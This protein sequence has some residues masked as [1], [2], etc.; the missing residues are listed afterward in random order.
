MGR[1][2]IGM[3]TRDADPGGPSS[4]RDSLSGAPQAAELALD[5]YGLPIQRVPPTGT[6]SGTRNGATF[7][8]G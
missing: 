4:L 5:A 1:D 8:A 7:P 2:G 6:P 3:T